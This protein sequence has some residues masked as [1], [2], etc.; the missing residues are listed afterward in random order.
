V[1]EDVVNGDLSGSWFLRR[2][3]SAEKS[4]GGFG[5]SFIRKSVD[6]DAI[7]TRESSIFA[8]RVKKER[9]EQR[10]KHSKHFNESPLHTWL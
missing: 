4:E 8:E 6:G 2:L 3:V 1:L 7:V 10:R 9:R 5:K